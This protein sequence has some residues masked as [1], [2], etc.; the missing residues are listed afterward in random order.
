MTTMVLLRYEEKG[1]IVVERE[2][3]RLRGIRV[4]KSYDC[5]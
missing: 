2:G 1:R 4:V 5:Q 3:A